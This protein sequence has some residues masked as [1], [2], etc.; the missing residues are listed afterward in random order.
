LLEKNSII[1]AHD[2]FS[3]NNRVFFPQV[4]LTAT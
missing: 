3:N 1:V 2:F 4:G